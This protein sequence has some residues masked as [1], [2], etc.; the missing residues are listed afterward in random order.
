MKVNLYLKNE[1]YDGIDFNQSIFKRKLRDIEFPV[2]PRVGEFINVEQE[3]I[4]D[5]NAC[6]LYGVVET[7]EYTIIRKSKEY[8]HIKNTSFTIDIFLKE[9]GVFIDNIED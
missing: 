8:K 1:D 4:G 9:T 5:D 3:R 7:I 2:I 6:I